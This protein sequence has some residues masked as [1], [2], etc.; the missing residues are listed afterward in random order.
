M[1]RSHSLSLTLT[2]FASVAIPVTHTFKRVQWSSCH[3][4]DVWDTNL[5]QVTNGNKTE[6]EILADTDS[7]FSGCCQE[8]CV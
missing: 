8:H 5:T 4:L 7:Y 3:E 2:L 1:W 6:I